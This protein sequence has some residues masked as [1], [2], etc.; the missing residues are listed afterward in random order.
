VMTIRS[1][2]YHSLRFDYIEEAVLPFEPIYLDFTGPG[3]VAPR[4]TPEIEPLPLYGALVWRQSSLSGE[5]LMVAPYGYPQD[6]PP[7]GDGVVTAGWFCLGQQ[8][9]NMLR[10]EQGGIVQAGEVQLFMQDTEIYGVAATCWA[11]ACAGVDHEQPQNLAGYAVL[12]LSLQEVNDKAMA[13]RGKDYTAEY[14][15]GWGELLWAMVT[16]TLAALSITEA[17]EVEIV[18]APMERRVRKRA[19]KRRWPIAQK[20]IIRSHSKRYRDRPLPS[21]EEAHYSH[22]F[23]RRA[24]IAHYP[25]GTMLAD[26]RPDL[27]TACKRPPESNCGFCRKVKRPACIVGPEDRPLVLKTLVKRKG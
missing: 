6:D 21:G 9:R 1:K 12:P 19:E 20:V 15:V 16:K 11:D 25:L 4:V 14:L 10:P 3:M 24:T 18:D 17:L 8:P 2:P 27:V 23:W 22:R 5:V 13:R 26:A 7:V